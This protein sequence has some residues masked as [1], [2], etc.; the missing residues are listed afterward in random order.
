MIGVRGA[1]SRCTSKSAWLAP[2]A[3]SKTRQ[4]NCNRVSIGADELPVTYNSASSKQ[5]ASQ[6]TG[7]EA[8][9]AWVLDFRPILPLQCM[10]CCI[11]MLVSKVVCNGYANFLLSSQKRTQLGLIDPLCF[12]SHTQSLLL[13]FCTDIFNRLEN[14]PVSS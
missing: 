7:K 10:M 4:T 5:N 8:Q 9:V 12:A 13:Y 14:R 1:A 3:T 6:S 11:L 2:L